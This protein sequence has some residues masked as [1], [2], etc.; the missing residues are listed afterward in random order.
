MLSV[1]GAVGLAVL[2]GAAAADGQAFIAAARV[3][4]AGALNLSAAV[5][6]WAWLFAGFLLYVAALRFLTDA[7]LTHPLPQLLCWFG[8]TIVGVAVLSGDV[9]HWPPTRIGAAGVAILALGYVLAGTT[10]SA[11]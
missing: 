3:W 10:S 9:A 7:G 1:S 11:P 6:S 2:L 4:T 8:A 5:V